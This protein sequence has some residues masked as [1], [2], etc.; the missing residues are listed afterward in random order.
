MS[1]PRNVDAAVAQVPGV[2]LI[3]LESLAEVGLADVSL[4][5]VSLTDVSL[6]GVDPAWS[7]SHA[8]RIAV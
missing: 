1:V 7:G 8:Q 6:T 2:T 4:T 5:D 3:D